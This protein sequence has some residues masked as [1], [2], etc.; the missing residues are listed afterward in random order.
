MLDINLFRPE[1]GG[2]PDLIRESQRR[3]YAPLEVVD[4]LIELDKTWRE[5]FSGAVERRCRSRQRGIRVSGEGDDKYLNAT[6]EQP[7]CTFHKGEWLDPKPFLSGTCR[8]TDSRGPE[9]LMLAASPAGYSTCFRKGAG[10]HGRDT[11][12]IFRVHQFEKVEQFCIVSPGGT[13]SWDKHEELLKNSLDFYQEIGLPYRVVSIVSGALNDAAA[14]KYDLEAWFP[15]SQTFRELARN[16]EIRY[17]NKKMNDQAKQY[18]HLLNSTLTATERTV[19][20]ILETSQSEEGVRVP[21]GLQPFMMGIELIPFV[22]LPTATKEAKPKK[23]KP[24]VVPSGLVVG[25][26]VVLPSL[27][28]GAAGASTSPAAISASA[29]SASSMPGEVGFTTS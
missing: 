25:A 29:V 21:S 28:D 18:V 6:S 3:R 14:K 24:A 22:H 1:K 10:S 16:L 17:G 15:A 12:G 27:L 4:E 2:D 26:E 23:G 11:L 20:C 5:C 13:E 19:C 7:L 8:A 9:N